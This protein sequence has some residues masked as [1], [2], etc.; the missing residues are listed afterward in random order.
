MVARFVP[1]L[2]FLFAA[3]AAIAGDCGRQQS[4]CCAVGCSPCQ[5]VYTAT[6]CQP[7]RLVERTVMVPHWVTEK[8]KVKTVECRA[9]E[10]E[11]TVTFYEE[12]PETRKV[13]KHYTVMVEQKRTRIEKYCVMEPFTRNVTHKYTVMVPHTERRKGFRTVRRPVVR[14]VTKT[15][16][17]CVEHIETRHGTREVCRIVPVKRLRT[18]CED[19]GHWQECV[20]RRR[21]HCG[22]GRPHTHGCAVPRRAQLVWVPRIVRKQVEETVMTRQ[23]VREPCTYQVK[24]MRPETRTCTVQVCEYE[25]VQEPCEYTVTVCRPETRS[26]T[27]QVQDCRRVEKSRKVEYTVCVPKKETKTFEVTECK[28]VRRERKEKYTV[29]VPHEVEKE[30]EVQV[31]KLVPRKITERVA[32]CC[33]PCAPCCP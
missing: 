9:E 14:N 6:P 8:R 3:E 10:R 11:R 31:C 25:C 1:V 16:T 13:T 28:T 2:A 33:T 29:M 19:Q 18:V 32:I 7:Y 21:V 17:V 20:V 4:P 26:K 24:V 15:Y 23:M 30:I 22:C 12:V 27:V 5:V